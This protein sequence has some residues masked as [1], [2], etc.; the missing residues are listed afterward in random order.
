MPHCHQESTYYSVYH[1]LL[2]CP[3]TTALFK[4]DGYDFT[5]CN[6]VIDIVYNTDVTLF[7][8]QN[9]EWCCWNHFSGIDNGTSYNSPLLSARVSGKEPIAGGTRVKAC[10]AFSVNVQHHFC[11]EPLGDRFLLAPQK[12]HVQPFMGPNTRHDHALWGIKRPVFI[13]GTVQQSIGFSHLPGHHRAS[14][15]CLS[16]ARSLAWLGKVFRA[17]PV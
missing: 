3:I 12:R 15:T 4:K 10:Y 7:L 6:S 8:L 11:Q 5:S 16:C 9:Q 1:I 2:E 13:S 14:R 17:G